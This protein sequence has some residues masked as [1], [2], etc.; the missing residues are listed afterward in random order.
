M[1]VSRGKEHKGGVKT[2][3]LSKE[4]EKSYFNLEGEKRKK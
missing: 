3:G 1:H 2:A 4:K